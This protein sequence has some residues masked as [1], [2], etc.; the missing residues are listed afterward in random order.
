VTDL[1]AVVRI[2]TRGSSLARWQ[3]DHVAGLLRAAHKGLRV[4]IT[5]IETHGDRVLDKPL[6]LIGGKGLFTAELEAA[7][8][9]G[10]VDL[11]VHSL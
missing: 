11:A 7:L 10:E 9:D 1:P 5:V 8:R 2:G 4:E 6:P 3:A